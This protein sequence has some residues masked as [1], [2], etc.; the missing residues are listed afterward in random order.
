SLLEADQN[1]RKEAGRSDT[2]A[3]Y[4]ANQA[5]QDTLEALRQAGLIEP[6]AE[7]EEGVADL[8]RKPVSFPMSRD[9]R[10]QALARGDEGFLLGLAYST[11][12]GLGRIHPFVADLRVGGVEVKFVVPELGFTITIAEIV[13]TECRTINEFTSA[14]DQP[15]CFT[16]GYGLAL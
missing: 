6:R 16:Q 3:G 15:P 9:A 10:L 8:T 4:A 13:V 11:L 7:E 5:P 14:A 1:D 12:R 2:K